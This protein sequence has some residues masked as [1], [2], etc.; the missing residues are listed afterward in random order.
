[1]VIDFP[2]TLYSRARIYIVNINA[3]LRLSLFGIRRKN[4]EDE[5]NSS[6]KAKGKVFTPSG[7]WPN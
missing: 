5:E 6:L 4:E 7:F 2:A 1:M 3:L